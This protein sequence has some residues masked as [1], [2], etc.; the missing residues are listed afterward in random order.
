MKKTTTKKAAA[1]KTAATKNVTKEAADKPV[2]KVVRTKKVSEPA[3][4]AVKKTVRKDAPE[5]KE[6]TEKK[7]VAKVSKPVAVPAPVAAPT[8]T[9]VIEVREHAQA[10]AAEPATRSEKQPVEK[11]AESPRPAPKKPGKPRKPETLAIGVG[12]RKEAV[13]RV[14]IKLGSGKLTV[15]Q[16]PYEKYFTTQTMRLSATTP[17]RVIERAQ[18]YDVH[19][20]VVGG[21]VGAQADA[22][23]LGFS[24]ALLA[25]NEEWRSSLRAAG[26]L[27]VD[28]RQK[29]RKKYGQK[30]ARRK[31][32]FV[33][34]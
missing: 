14:W 15:N 12:R 16:H 9:P 6:P 26:L 34:R 4:K 5:K 32:Q 13:A 11:K 20:N 2:K 17:F 1:P 33:K 3:P 29:E 10:K 27:T 19:A 8:A 30:R 23:R 21:G 31:F 24:R 18:H 7:V 28:A 22:V 25:L